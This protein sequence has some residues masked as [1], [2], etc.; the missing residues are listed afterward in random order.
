MKPAMDPLKTIA[1]HA[2]V[3]FDEWPERWEAATHA[4]EMIGLHYEQTDLEAVFSEV[5]NE[6]NAS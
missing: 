4:L 1:K 2:F 6:G 5:E 3:A